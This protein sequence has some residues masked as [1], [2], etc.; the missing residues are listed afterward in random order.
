MYR[1]YLGYSGNGHYCSDINE[2]DVNNGGCST[3]PTVECI[4]TRVSETYFQQTF[5]STSKMGNYVQ[6]SFRC[7]SCPPGWQGD[8]RYCI[9]SI[10]SDTGSPSSPTSGICSRQ[11]FCHPL[12]TCSETLSGPICICPPGY[13]GSGFGSMGCSPGDIM[14][15][16]CSSNPCLVSEN[17]ES[18]VGVSV[19]AQTMNL[20]LRTA[21]HARPMAHHSHVPVL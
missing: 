7:G 12:A 3:A 19:R 13:V 9:R 1:S 10:P 16:P 5:N 17:T 20:P 4:N 18:F 2:C 21:A 11:S 8:G 6:G 14:R 15:H